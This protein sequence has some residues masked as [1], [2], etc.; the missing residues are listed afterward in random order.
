M[1]MMTLGRTRHP[2]RRLHRVGF[3]LIEAAIVTALIGLGVVALVQLLAAGSVSNLEAAEL[4]TAVQLANNVQEMMATL[5]LFDP[6]QPTTWSAKEASLGLY[7]NVT[8]FDGASINP[9]VDASRN[10]LSGMSD[11]TQ[12]ISVDSVSEGTLSSIV[13]DTA[14]EPTARVTVKVMRAGVEEYRMSWMV[15]ATQ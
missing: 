5:P 7:D 15:A 9:P 13:P 2:R 6:Q 3:S 10:A 4:T 14:T 8:D 1:M 12:V 11:W